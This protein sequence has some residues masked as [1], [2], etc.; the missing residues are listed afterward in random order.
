MGEYTKF[1]LQNLGRKRIRTAL[2]I[3]GISIGVASVI[4]I[5]N[6]AQMG[7][8][9]ITGEMDSLGLSGLS[10]TA[11]GKET[12]AALDDDDLN[13]IKGMDAVKQAAPVLMISTEI[14]SRDQDIQAMVWGVDSNAGE[15][16]SLQPV[17]GRLINRNDV[18]TGA[19]VCLIDEQFAVKTYSRGNIVG[20]KISILC[21]GTYQ[22]YSVVGIIKTGTGLLQNVIGNYI[23]TFVYVPY[24]NLQTAAQKKNFDEIAVKVKSGTPTDDAGKMIV[25]RLNYLNGTS[26]AYLSTDLAKQREGLT[27]ILDVVTLILSAVGAISL[28]VASLS[29]MTMMLVSVNERTRE[30]GIKKAL[31]A[32]RGAIMLEFLLEAALLSLIGCAVGAASGLVISWAASAYFHTL[33]RIRPDIMLMASAFALLSGTA[34]G[35]YPA[36]QAA[37]L[38]PVDAL[39]QE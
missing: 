3:L 34:F 20:K 28:L 35:V 36:W 17:Y 18:R 10:I 21:G 23:P 27:E 30:I 38:R 29:I 13:L 33:F 11:S 1:A 16:I 7:T 32:T 31:G 19:S 2:T 26:D 22:Q 6:I 14:S 37:R 25:T 8:D 39:R 15:I 5:G 12:S 9:T 4:L 24:T